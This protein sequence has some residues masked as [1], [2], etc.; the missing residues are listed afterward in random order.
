MDAIA[1]KDLRKKYRN[2]IGRT[3][4][5][6]LNGLT[7]SIAPNE[8]FGFLGR[9]G[10]GKTTTIK[11]LCS[12]LRPT[13]GEALIFGQPARSR[14]SRARVGY[15]PENPYFYEY[16]NPRETL[17]FYGRLRGLSS[18]QR[19]SEW[20]RLSEM[21]DLAS[22]GKQ[23][24]REFSKG[25]RQRLGFAVALVGDPE[26][27][28]LDEPMSGLDPV[29]RRMIRELILLMRDRKKTIFFS[30]HVLGD[31]EQICDRVGILVNGTMTTH[32]HIDQ[33]LQQ[34]IDRVEMIVTG[35]GEAAVG[36]IGPA[37]DTVRKSDA[38]HHLMVNGFDAANAVAKRV[39]AAGGNLREFN[40]VK[41]S[42]EDLFFEKQEP[43]A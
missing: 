10:A 13:G 3:G 2:H 30:S 21:L 43:A 4:A 20:S 29:G 23:R 33:L 34:R 27:L 39:Y 1:L 32:G 6:P 15:L 16:L 25:M 40:P 8:V 17:D 24:V 12:L 36:V 11:I 41:A 19:A 35:L 18:A 22:I 31:V 28:I 26:V 7:L 14:A 42:L 38:G 37:C 5:Y 9:N